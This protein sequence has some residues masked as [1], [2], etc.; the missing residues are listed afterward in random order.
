MITLLLIIPIIGSLM[1]MLIQENSYQSQTKMKTIALSSS[2]LNFLIS[3]FI[4][5][6]FDSSTSQYQF[7]YEFNQL[8][9]CHFNL[10]IDGIS[11][12]FVLL[13]T[14]IT[15]IALFS[16]YSNIKNNLKY[17]LISFLMLETLQILAFVSLDLLLFYI[18]FESVLPV[19]FII[20]VL[21][22]HGIDRFRSA[23]LL[24][25][26]TL[27]G[28][29]PMLL[30]ILLIYSY[31]GTTDFQFL[32]LYEISLDSQK[33]IWLSYPFSKDKMTS[34]DMTLKFYNMLFAKTRN[35]SLS[36]L[37]TAVFHH[38]QTNLKRKKWMV[39]N[40][41][42]KSL[43]V[44]GSN[45]GSTINFLYYNRF[46]RNIVNIPTNL[47]SIILGIILSDGHLFK[48]KANNTLF[49]FKQTI[50]RF[51]YFWSV[52]N[53]FSHFCQGYPRLY[54][55]TIKGKNIVQLFSQLEYYLVLHIGIIYFMLIK[56]KVLHIGIIYFMLIKIKIIPLDL[57]NLLEYA[58]LA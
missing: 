51:D 44:Y 6:E 25:L 24:F 42:C 56:I 31:L 58:A 18:F 27:A 22:G 28:S 3:I 38:W 4:W 13:T 29:L 43:V 54:I 48:N 19:I 36:H 10:G 47:N 20:I 16:N 8:S 7:V 14:F 57:Y 40:R 50:D 34:R 53:K 33:I 41:N 9:F 52:F 23:Y 30:S 45:L 21:F 2:L 17:F 1:I 15:P 5:L 39:E 49:S 46:I 26:Y 35:F 37:K 11:L 55:I 32:S 12:Y